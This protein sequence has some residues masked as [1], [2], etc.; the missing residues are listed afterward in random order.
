MRP[1]DPRKFG[2]VDVALIQ[3]VR[4]D[5]EYY[6]IKHK[7]AF[8]NGTRLESNSR[9]LHKQNTVLLET[10]DIDY[11]KRYMIHRLTKKL[12]YKPRILGSAALSYC[13]LADGSADAL[14]F[15]QPGG[16]RTIDSPAGYLIARETAC[17]FSDLSGK[18][19]DTDNIEVG[20][21]SKVNLVGS[22]SKKILRKLLK[23]VRTP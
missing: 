10:G 11:M 22:P 19:R 3:S 13:L 7:G 2:D 21:H 23:L 18:Q 17:F 20:F 16:A 15:A 1:S 14:I 5:D 6:A 9:R 4:G 8:L 12:V